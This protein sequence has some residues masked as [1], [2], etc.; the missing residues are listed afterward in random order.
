MKRRILTS[1]GL[2][3]V[4]SVLLTAYLST[5][6][7]YQDFDSKIKEE[8][9]AEIYYIK[10]AV[11]AYGEGY[12]ESVGD[13]KNRITLIG[14]DGFVIYDSEVPV[15]DLDNHSDR[16]EVIQATASGQGEATRMSDTLLQQN[17]YYAVKLN[18]GNILRMASAVDSVF[19]TLAGLIPWMAIIVLMILAV[20][21]AFSGYLT[22]RIVTPINE[23]NLDDTSQN[24]IYDELAPLLLKIDRQK[25]TISEQE[26]SLRRQK[27][28]FT[29]ITENMSEGILIVNRKMKVLSYNSSA[30][31][32]L[33]AS[34]MD[35][36]PNV[37]KFN[38]SE[39]FRKAIE[40]ALE[41]KHSEQTIRIDERSYLLIANPVYYET[42]LAGA[43][44]IIIDVTEKE[45]RE[46]LRREFTANVSHELKTP[47]TVISGAAEIIKTG[48]AKPE[49]IV[50]FA[51]NIYDEAQRLIALISD[52]IKLSQLD[53]S[54]TP[55]EKE[56]VDLYKV[57]EDV[58]GH[59]KDLAA[60]K[61]VTLEIKGS[62]QVVSGVPQILEEMI[63]NLSENAI[64]YNKVNGKVTVWVGRKGGAAKLV[65]TDTGIGIPHSQIDRVFE[66]FYRVEK[67]R[68]KDVGGTGLGLSIVKHGAAYHDATLEIE[69][70]P[71]IGT[72]V[73]LTFGAQ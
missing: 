62:A 46:S 4:I 30:L 70:E 66:R 58:V 33:G 35:G 25:K 45:E 31:K 59:L 37:L 3:A 29:A 64:K 51:G 2:I 73:S 27:E 44:I 1:M 40:S 54:T 8:V 38:R 24:V 6:V 28:E 26:E 22:K 47:L 9:Q 52:I 10:A 65:V 72:K 49:D 68:S 23:L 67:S 12:L 16:P 7:Y 57:A 18:D 41:G 69:S 19:H 39:H 17:Y 63:Y 50:H 60:E 5:I 20:S 42:E 34:K 71:G 11:E 61:Q 13:S 55:F 15:G 14:S 56:P 48:I 53:E 43:A 21:I 36:T 32:L